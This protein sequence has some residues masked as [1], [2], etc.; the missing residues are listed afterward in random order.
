[1]LSPDQV[2]LALW[3]ALEQRDWD[4]AGSLLTPDFRCEFPQSRECFD[5]D[6][7]LWVNRAYPGDWHL[8]VRRVLV[9]GDAVVTETEVRIDGRVDTALSFFTVRDGRIATLREYWP[10]PFEIPTW[11]LG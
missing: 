9:Q 2:V 7:W 6:R 3:T 1:M 11:R 5:R 10:E 4:R 8:E